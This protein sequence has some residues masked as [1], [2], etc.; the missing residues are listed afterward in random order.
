MSG[1]SNFS[2]HRNLV[3]EHIQTSKDKQVQSEDYM[4]LSPMNPY[5]YVPQKE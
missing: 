3:F 5:K 2:L 4:K 1:R